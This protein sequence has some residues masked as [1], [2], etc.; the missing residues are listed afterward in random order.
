MAKNYTLLFLSPLPSLN[1][2]NRISALKTNSLTAWSKTYCSRQ[3]SFQG[4]LEQIALGTSK[5]LVYV[6]SFPTVDFVQVTLIRRSVGSSQS[7]AV[8]HFQVH[9]VEFM[10][11]NVVHRINNCRRQIVEI[12]ALII[13][14]TGWLYR[15]V[16][17]PHILRLKTQRQRFW[18]LL[19]V[20]QSWIVENE[21]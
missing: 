2:I 7:F 21:S 10:F 15:V 19:V 1:E 17:G 12:G 8:L 20:S 9:E 5:S 6:F 13:E 11:F 16:F 18:Q 4:S 3:T 14:G